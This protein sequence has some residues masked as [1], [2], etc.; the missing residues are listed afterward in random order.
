[1]GLKR[2]YP[3]RRLV[4]ACFLRRSASVQT[5]HVNGDNFE[6]SHLWQKEG[7]RR[8]GA[9][10][11][12]CENL[13]KTFSFKSQIAFFLPHFFPHCCHCISS[14]HSVCKLPWAIAFLSFIHSIDHQ[15]GGFPLERQNKDLVNWSS[16]RPN[17]QTKQANFKCSWGLPWE[18][19]WFWSSVSPLPALQ[20]KKNCS[21]IVANK[22]P[23]DNAFEQFNL[24]QEI[25]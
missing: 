24:P 7:N 17:T 15:Q 4:T 22:I 21:C 11:E 2:T 6:N 13:R 23:S 20:G 9:S 3:T 10:I 8:W 16:H 19:F 25:E 18:K 12:I 1:M 14:I 5:S